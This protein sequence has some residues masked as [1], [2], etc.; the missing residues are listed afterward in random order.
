MTAEYTVVRHRDGRELE[1]LRYGPPDAFRLGRFATLGWSG[2][3]PH[4]LGCAALLPERCTA[5]ASLAGVAPFEAEGL[6]WLGGMGPE[7]VTEFNTAVRSR[8]ELEA[9]LD[10]WAAGL[11]AVTGEQIAASFGE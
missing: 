3:G 11:A 7:N 1:V 9:L 4:A 6:D 8:A 10:E 5:A 2:G